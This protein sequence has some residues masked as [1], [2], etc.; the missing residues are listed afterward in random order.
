MEILNTG[1]EGLAQLI[2]PTYHDS[3]GWFFEFY[4]SSR[5]KDI[6][7]GLDFLQDNISFSKKNVLRGLHL[8]LD[9]SAQ[10]KLV[11]VISGRVLD[12]VV[13]MRSNSPT[14]GKSFQLELNSE[15]KNMLFVPEGF[16]HG[17]SALEESIFVYKCSKEYNSAYETG[18]VWNDPDLNIDWKITNPILSDKDRQL[19]TFRELTEKSLNSR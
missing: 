5:F 8:Q 11:T 17:F 14:F 7:G 9:P 15:T 2:P 13:D 16:A 1:I 3:R 19:P 12:V 10:A 18:I 6:T 4:K